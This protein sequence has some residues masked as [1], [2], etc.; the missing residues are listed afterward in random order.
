MYGS[1]GTHC[2]LVGN[3]FD[4]AWKQQNAGAA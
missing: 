4:P 3:A 1:S 2:P